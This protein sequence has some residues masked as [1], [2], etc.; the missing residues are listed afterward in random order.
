MKKT[1]GIILLIVGIIIIYQVIRTKNELSMHTNP[2]HQSFSI[3]TIG[4]IAFII[5]G[6]IM[7]RKKED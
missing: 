5:V 1:I 2:G 7:I 6:I 4:S 3:A